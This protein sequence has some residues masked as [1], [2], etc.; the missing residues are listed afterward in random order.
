MTNWDPDGP[1]QNLLVIAG[2]FN[3]VQNKIASG[4]A[5]WNGTEWMNLGSGITGLATLSQSTNSMTNWDPDGAGPQPNYLVAAGFIK[6]AG[7]VSVNGIARWDG[8]S[9]SAIPGDSQPSNN[10]GYVTTW[11]PDGDGPTAAYL[12]GGSSSLV[13]YYRWNGTNRVFVSFQPYNGAVRT[14]TRFDADGSGPELERLVLA[15]EFTTIGGVAARRVAM[16]NGMAWLPFGGGLG[17]PTTGTESVRALATYDPDGPDG[18][19]P[20]ELYAA[21]NFT[22]AEGLPVSGIARWNGI[23]WLPLGAATVGGITID[24]LVAVG[25]GPNGTAP[26]RLVVGGAFTTFAGIPAQR[27]AV[28]DGAAWSGPGSEFPTSA[29]LSLGALDPDAGGP[30]EPAILVGS[31]RNSSTPGQPPLHLGKLVGSTYQDVGPGTNG[32]IYA[33]AP[34][35][36]DGSGPLPPVAV[37]AGEATKIN[38]VLCN[39]IAIWNGRTTTALGSGMNNRVNAVVS[40]DSDGPGPLQP[41]IVA[42]GDFS[43]AGGQPASRAAFWD[44]SAWQQLGSGLPSTITQS[45]FVK[46]F[47]PDGPDGPIV[48]WLLA[49]GYQSPNHFYQRWNGT[50]WVNIGPSFALGGTSSSTPSAVEF[51]EDTDGPGEA[52]LVTG[53]MLTINAP[54]PVL[55]NGCFGLK[56]DGSYQSFGNGPQSGSAIALFDFD[57]D[58]PLPARLVSNGSTYTAHWWDGTFWIPLEAGLPPQPNYTVSALTS[59]DVDGPGPEPSQLYALG[60][61]RPSGTTV[62]EGRLYRL[63]SDTWSYFGSTRVPGIFTTTQVANRT[64]VID[65]DLDGPRAPSLLIAGQTTTIDNSV[66]SAYVGQYGMASVFADLDGDAIVGLSDIAAL[67][68][69]WSSSVPPAPAWLDLDSSGDVGPGDLAQVIQNWGAS[70]SN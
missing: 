24:A 29:V 5:A 21:G 68:A 54:G 1:A 14:G 43:T 7:G 42:V 26:L 33:V 36:P 2:R 69:S 17:G 41:V 59:F 35:D 55:V 30:A 70:C 6:T 53:G 60:N 10:Y 57:G 45:T 19:A 31:S 52:V 13:G 58:G 37:L 11:D 63:A 67:I 18:S 8:S 22:L 4:I 34:H 15:G 16:W 48:P 25:L 40:W 51:D 66:V 50:S 3:A 39:H 32:E 47:D 9:W 62:T 56:S 38:G 61:Y 44:G 12:I 27:V 49:L 64:S 28:W 20:P 65:F 46:V 23:S